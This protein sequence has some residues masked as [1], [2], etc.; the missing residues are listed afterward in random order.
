MDTPDQSAPVFTTKRASRNPKTASRAARRVPGQPS[1][2]E[3]AQL[4]QILLA[5]T[6]FRNGVFTQRPTVEWTGVHGKIAD[7]F[8]DMLRTRERRSREVSRVCRMV[9]KEGRQI[10]WNIG[11][12]PN[13]RGD[14]A[15]LLDLK[16][17]GLDGL[18]VLKQIRSEQ[19]FRL[20][21]VVIYTASRR[22]LDLKQACG[23]G[24]N[25]FLAKSIFPDGGVEDLRVFARCFAIVNE[26][27]P[28]SPRPHR[29]L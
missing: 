26:P 18:D 14:A 19:A 9:G 12:L 2:G 3:E 11:A 7:A 22:E 6:A 27:P 13:I 10:T 28:G 16:M 4:T 17:P 29:T 8:N 1:A 25:G 15:I 20:I 21:P 24:A 5:M 23:L